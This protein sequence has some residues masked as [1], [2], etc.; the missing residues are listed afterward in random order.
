VN[1]KG[2]RYLVEIPEEQQ[3]IRRICELYDA[4]VHLREIC[5]FLNIEGIPSRGPKWHKFSLYRVL[6]RA[7]YEDP[8]R[9][10]K[11]SLSRKELLAA[12]QVIVNRDKTTAVARAAEL[13]TQGLSLRQIGDRLLG[14]GLLPPRS[15]AWHAAGI[16]DLLLEIDRVK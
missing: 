14:E 3:G 13:R 1:E 15:E 11:S 2:R 8:E 10:R 16:R 9:P 7:G 5:K 12:K 4:D 6:K